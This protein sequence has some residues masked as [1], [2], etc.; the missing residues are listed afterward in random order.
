MRGRGPGFWVFLTGLG[1]LFVVVILGVTFV[2]PEVQK[3]LKL[4]DDVVRF[5]KAAQAGPGPFTPPADIQASAAAA[6]LAAGAAGGGGGAPASD[7]SESGSAAPT[8]SDAGSASGGGAESVEPGTFGG[9]GSNRVCDREK[10]I[11]ALLAKPD[12]LKAWAEALGVEP[13]PEAVT[14]FIRKLRPVTLTRDTQLTNH[15]FTDG[16]VKA[17]QAILQKGTA[18]LVDKD[19]KPVTR[20]RC[21]NPLK[22]PIDLAEDTE[23][24]DCPKNYQPPPPCDYYDYDDS[25]YESYDDQDFKGEYSS[26]D[27]Q[28]KC[29]RPNPEPPPVEKGDEPPPTEDECANDPTA[30]GC[31]EQC[32]Q[33]S[34][35]PFCDGASE[36]EGEGA[37]PPGSEETPTEEVPSEGQEAPSDPGTTTPEGGEA[38]ADGQS[39]P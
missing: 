2:L 10:L 20:C 29:Y 25:K 26:S 13:T 35:L 28:G 32:Q 3:L 38:P 39:T 6:G 36:L 23:C 17:F 11:K 24:V 1:A 8:G 15:S 21:G 9:T 33:D 27:F 5:Q 7:G 18:V 4:K 37:P 14:A 34:S 16:D 31:Q 19:G 22:E 30:P 12:R